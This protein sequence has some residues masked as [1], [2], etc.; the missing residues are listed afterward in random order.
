M[1][2]GRE[3]GEEET[4]RACVRRSGSRVVHGRPS[5]AD[6]KDRGEEEWP[7]WMDTVLSSA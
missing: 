2:K 6:W 5:I 1:S 7:I 4:R 3:G